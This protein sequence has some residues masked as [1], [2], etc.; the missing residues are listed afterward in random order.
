MKRRDFIKLTA[1][2]SAFALMPF[3]VKALM[4]SINANNLDFGNR[5]VV[6]IN[7]AGANDGLNTLV[8][9]NQYDL[10]S[11]LRP[12]I[13]VPDTGLKA[14]IP[15]DSTLNLDQQVGLNP[16]LTHFKSLYEDGWLKVLQGVGYP[17]QNKSHFAST[18]LYMTGNDGNSVLNG[19][20]SGWMG[21]FMEQFYQDKLKEDFPLAVQIGSLKNSLGFHGV[22]EHGMSINLTGQDPSGF[23]SVLNGLGG[24]PP[25]NIPT[26]DFGK[27]LEYIIKI[28]ELSNFYASTISDAFNKG[29]NIGNYPDTDIADQLK[30]VAKLISGGLESKFYMVRLSGFD[31][32]GNQVEKSGEILG[33][34]HTLLT[35]L[36]QAIGAFFKDIKEQNVADDIV[37]LTYSE[38]GRKVKENGNLGTDHGE[39]AP[40]FVFGKS[41]KGGMAG[42]NPDLTEATD[43]NNYQIKTVQHDYRQVMSTILQ[44]FL[45]ASNTVVDTSLFNY[46]T[47]ESFVNY[48]ID[49]LFKEEYQVDETKYSDILNTEGSFVNTEESVGWSAFPNPCKDL[50]QLRCDEDVISAE[51][52]I[53]DASSRLVFK[54]TKDMFN[55]SIQL[56][57]G[58]LKSESYYLTIN[59]DENLAKIQL[60]K[61]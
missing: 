45:G 61:I 23:Y 55:G 26:S 5:K 59:S 60:M 51:I 10:Y 9:I 13:K 37:G 4:N 54:E 50:L 43:K 39:I 36:S 31:T 47:N 30:T 24:A 35:E 44:D 14:Y 7:L 17:S 49:E 53:Y 16:A 48:K 41:V 28:D 6:L 56:S 29:K 12:T 22:A 40:M 18:D 1:S 52:C 33:K 27:E 34:H 2:A 3:E 46:T 25:N 19:K 8:P 15:L 21:R 38:F 42:I 57:I 20:N 58:H 11:S 32:H